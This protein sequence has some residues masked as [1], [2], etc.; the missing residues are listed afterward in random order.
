MLAMDDGYKLYIVGK[1][2]V[3]RGK[4]RVYVA[5]RKSLYSKVSSTFSEDTVEKIHESRLNNRE[6]LELTSEVALSPMK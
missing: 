5:A 2:S 4:R 6:Y 1:G 3:T